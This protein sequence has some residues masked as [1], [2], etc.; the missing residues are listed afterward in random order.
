MCPEAKWAE[1]LNNELP[2]KKIWRR[3]PT[4]ATPRDRATGMKVL[5]RTLYLRRD[6]TCLLCDDTESITHTCACTQYHNQFWKPLIDLAVKMGETYPE[7]VSTWIATGAISKEKV[8]GSEVSSIWDI[9]WRCIYA[10]ICKYRNEGGSFDPQRAL[11]RTVAMLIGRANAYARRWIR[12][13][14][15]GQWISTPRGIAEMYRDKK[16]L[17]MDENA[18]C[19]ISSHLEDMAKS[20]Q[21]M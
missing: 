19:V 12:W 2:F 3:K 1:K 16:L 20:L 10:E 7:D 17:F 21:L 15:T 8:M 4:F 9:G 11:K 14:D 18:W 13:V 5:H 6:E